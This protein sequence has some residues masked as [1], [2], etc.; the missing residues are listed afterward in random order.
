MCGESK[1]GGCLVLLLVCCASVI[2]MLCI[3]KTAHPFQYFEISLIFQCKSNNMKLKAL[4]SGGDTV[5]GGGS[6]DGG[7]WW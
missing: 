4:F 7:W 6:G 3:F 1:V 5:V 2:K